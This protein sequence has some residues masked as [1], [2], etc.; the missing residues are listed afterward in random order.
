MALIVE[1]RNLIWKFHTRGVFALLR[2]RARLWKIKSTFTSGFNGT[3]FTT[4][5]SKRANM[6]LINFIQMRGMHE[7]YCGWS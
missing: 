3:E 1:M 7:E 6:I 5:L 4:V 2:M